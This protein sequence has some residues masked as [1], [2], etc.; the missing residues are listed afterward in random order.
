MT[1]TSDRNEKL[2]R[3]IRHKAR[4]CKGRSGGDPDLGR[5]YELAAEVPSAGVGLA[6]RVHRLLARRPPVTS[7][8]A[9]LPVSTR[10]S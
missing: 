1:R 2:A 10:S 5:L 3:R 8:T 7:A 9:A 4:R 6:I